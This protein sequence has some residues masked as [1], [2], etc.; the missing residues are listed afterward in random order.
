VP[1]VTWGGITGEDARIPARPNHYGPESP[2]L[3]RPASFAKMHSRAVVYVE[4]VPIL[5]TARLYLQLLVIKV[6]TL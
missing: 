5:S 6:Q 1:C 4:C 2:L 3:I